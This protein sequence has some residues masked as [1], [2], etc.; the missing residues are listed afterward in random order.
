MQS[1][2][3]AQFLNITC[4]VASFGVNVIFA[5]TKIYASDCNKIVKNLI[6]LSCE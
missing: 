6:G 3:G 2:N 1:S 5:V 4:V